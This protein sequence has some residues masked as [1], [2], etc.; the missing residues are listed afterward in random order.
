MKKFGV[1]LL[2]LELCYLVYWTGCMFWLV[3]TA[4]DEHYRTFHAFQAIHMLTVPSVI[5]SILE[6]RPYWFMVC[7]LLGTFFFDLYGVLDG[8]NHL[9]R[10]IDPTAWSVCMGDAGFTLGLVS[11]AI[12]W[13]LWILL[14]AKSEADRRREQ[15][16]LSRVG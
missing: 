14:N 2:I 16:L 13:T 11:L 6:T 10:L 4:S 1:F 3:T 7:I 9:D 12:L 5:V 8:V 15:L